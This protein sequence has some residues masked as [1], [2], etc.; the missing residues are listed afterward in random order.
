LASL[1]GGGGGVGLRC[2]FHRLLPLSYRQNYRC[3]DASL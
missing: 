2:D 1:D 3:I